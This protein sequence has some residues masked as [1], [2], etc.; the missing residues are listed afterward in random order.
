M[1]WFYTDTTGTASYKGRVLNPK[2]H[3]GQES[4]I[5]VSMALLGTIFI[6]LEKFIKSYAKCLVEQSIQIKTLEK[7]KHKLENELKGL[8][9][10]K[11]VDLDAPIEKIMNILQTLINNT[12]CENSKRQLVKVL[13]ILSSNRLYDPDFNFKNS[14]DD[15]EVYSWLQS[16]I[17]RDVG[18]Q[19]NANILDGHHHR[20]NCSSG[21]SS[22]EYSE[23]D[24]LYETTVEQM[25]D[26]NVGEWNFPIF[27]FNEVT[28]G[29]PLFYLSYFLFQ[30]HKLFQK[31]RIEEDSFKNFI[32][33]IESGYDSTNP[34][35]NSIHAADVLHNINYFIDHGL[36]KYVNDLEILA[37]L[38][39]AIIHDFKH[40]GFNNAFQINTKSEL[41]LKYN[42]RSILENFHCYQ[43]FKIINS[44]NGIFQNLTDVQKKEIRDIIIT[45]VLSTDMANHFDLVGKLKSKL[46]GNG[47]NPATNEKKDRIL[48][49]QIAIKCADISNPSKSW[50][51]Y[52]EWADRVTEEFYKQGDEEQR[53][54][55]DISAFMD[56]NKP[57]MT[58]CQI[59][60]INLFVE[61]L[62][63]TWVNVLP[64]LDICYQNVKTNLS[65]WENDIN[66]K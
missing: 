60:F 44:E 19:S 43:S 1:D 53:R 34:Y 41:A 27:Q 17:N 18:T 6:V 15:A 46:S 23:K 29:S 66:N 36:S 65:I 28:N 50:E 37:M 9:K 54:L 35:H 33:R 61:P 47:F 25:L 8:N 32:T 26:E 57:A 30:K 49:M 22:S 58:K 5:L 10:Q 11:K 31:F 52:K 2:I 13:S 38:L 7:E 40:P 59:S 62:Y 21:G 39:S 55:M 45:L 24:K 63:E 14:H 4:T 3:W 48:L 64:E 56:R 51:I 42:D 20:L 12:E 16:M